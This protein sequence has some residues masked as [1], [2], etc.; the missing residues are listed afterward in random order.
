MSLL[1]SSILATTAAL[2]TTFSV[3]V[4]AEPVTFD[5]EDGVHIYADLRKPRGEARGL[6]LLFHMADSNKDEYAPLA[7]ILNE[8][9]FATLA[10]DQRAGG[11]L[12]GSV[13]QTVAKAKRIYDY[14]D[15]IPDLEAAIAYGQAQHL[16]PLV[17][18]GSSYSSALVFV[19]AARHHE[20][21]ALLAFSPAEYIQG[22]SI[23]GEAGKL[24]IP[25]FL[26]STPSAGEVESAQTLARAVPHHK[27]VQYIPAVGVHGS[28]TL[29]IDEDPSGAAENWKHVMW[30]LDK[31]F[32]PH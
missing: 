17:V 5:A 31:S 16:G 1:R 6:I 21:R 23:V 26:T 12:W 10:V 32:P 19:V 27:A 28:S 18:W 30:F 25:A 8:A 15:A 7:P 9:G 4:K 11:N 14:A 3:P 20:V 24:S 13:N 29:R 22:Y 2:L